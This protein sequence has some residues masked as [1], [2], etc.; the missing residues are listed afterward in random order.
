MSLSLH[1]FTPDLAAE[2]PRSVFAKESDG[3]LLEWIKSSLHSRKLC[4]TLAYLGLARYD[5][6]A[7]LSLRSLPCFSR[8][9]TGMI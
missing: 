7:H 3:M 6:Y 8:Q 9:S 2:K 5:R 1:L 4:M